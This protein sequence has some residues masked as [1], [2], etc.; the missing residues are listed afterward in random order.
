VCK[1]CLC[2]DIP[3]GKAQK[4]NER[5]MIFF[6]ISLPYSIKYALFFKMDSDMNA[7]LPSKDMKHSVSC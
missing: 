1:G 2:N 5:E 7:P 6:D 4:K 3:K